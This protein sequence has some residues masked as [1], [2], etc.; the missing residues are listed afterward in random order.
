MHTEGEMANPRTHQ[1]YIINKYTPALTWV[2]EDEEEED[3]CITNLS[4]ASSKEG[5]CA[6][7]LVDGAP[8]RAI[9]NSAPCRRVRLPLLLLEEEAGDEEDEE[10][11]AYK[12]EEEG[13]T[14]Y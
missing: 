10:R 14:K 9:V 13:G 3:L 6:P 4:T 7:P 2:E 8:R 5:S 1:P 12:K 11:E